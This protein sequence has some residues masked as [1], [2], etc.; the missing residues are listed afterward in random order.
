VAVDARIGQVVS[1]YRIVQLLGRGGMGAVYLAVDAV[2]ARGLAKDRDDRYPTASELADD[3]RTA[4]GVS[5]GEIPQPRVDG[6]AVGD[7]YGWVSRP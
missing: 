1:S 6:V 2:F 3:L 7:G 4:L 5:S